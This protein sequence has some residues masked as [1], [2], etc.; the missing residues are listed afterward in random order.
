MTAEELSRIIHNTFDKTA[1]NIA[2]NTK[3]KKYTI[4]SLATAFY[5]GVQAVLFNLGITDSLGNFV[6]NNILDN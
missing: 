4:E 6:E 2:L 3:D 1:R 5:E